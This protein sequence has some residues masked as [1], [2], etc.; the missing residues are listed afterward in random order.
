MTNALLAKAPSNTCVLVTA[1]ARLIDSRTVV[2]LL[3]RGYRVVVAGDSSNSSREVVRRVGETAHVAHYSKS[4]PI[5]AAPLSSIARKPRWGAPD[6][7]LAWPR[8]MILHPCLSRSPPPR[9]CCHRRG[10]A[11]GG[12]PIKICQAHG[13]TAG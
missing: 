5:R 3:E 6:E 7:L 2:E 11:A 13:A 1:G 9:G 10:Q 4:R 12:R 8:W